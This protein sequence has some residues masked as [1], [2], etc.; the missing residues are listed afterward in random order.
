MR[1]MGFLKATPDTEAGVPPTPELMEKMGTFMEEVMAAGVV[2]STDGLSMSSMGRR[3]T[4][5]PGNYDT[6][7]GPFPLEQV[8]CAYSIFNVPSWDVAEHWTKRF[9]DVLG[10]GECELRPFIEFDNNG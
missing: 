1:I 3:I 8:F 5:T 10:G 9:L 6:K 2:E 4:G 7:D